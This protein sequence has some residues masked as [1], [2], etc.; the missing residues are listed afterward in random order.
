MILISHRGNINGPVPERENN[1]D[2][3]QEA[4]RAGYDVEIDVWHTPQNFFLGHNDPL[5]QVNQSFLTNARLWCHAKNK[6]ALARMLALNIHCFWHQ[7]D[8][9]T[10]TSKG[11]IWCYLNKYVDGCIVNQPEKDVNFKS[12]K[13]YKGIC[14]DY[15]GTYH[16][17]G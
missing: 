8:D 5:Y 13:S 2:Y 4:L 9:F 14:S 12:Y 11:Y 7:K 6:E 16:T 15:I 3:V 17:Q 10:L 1:P